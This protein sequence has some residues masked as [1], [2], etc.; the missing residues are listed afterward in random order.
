MNRERRRP[1]AHS[2]PQSEESLTDSDDDV[3]HTDDSEDDESWQRGEIDPNDSASATEEFSAHRGHTPAPQI[4]RRH[5]VN[6]PHHSTRYSHPALV[7]QVPQVPLGPSPVDYYPAMASESDFYGNYGAHPGRPPYAYERGFAP[8][9]SI[10][11]GYAPSHHSPYGPQ[12]GMVPWANGSPHPFQPQH[13]GYF[14]QG[15]HDMMPYQHPGYAVQ[16]SSPGPVAPQNAF[17]HIYPPPAA[18]AT[19]VG[20]PTRR[21]TPAPVEEKKPDPA[22]LAMQAQL[23]AMKAERKAADDAQKRA[24]LEKEIREQEERRIR[25]RMEDLRIASEAAKRDIEM[26]KVAAEAAAK[27]RIEEARR[28]EDERR[29]MEAELKAQAAR[30]ERERIEKERKAE[31]DRAAEMAK[32]LAEVERAAKEKYE[33]TKK[34]EA[35]RQAEQERQKK[36]IEDE[37]KAKILAEQKAAEEA[38]LAAELKLKELAAQAEV[39][40]E[41]L[42]QKAIQDH[43]EKMAA[44]KKKLADEETAAKAAKQQAHDEF[45]LKAAEEKAK[46][47]EAAAA[48][49]QAKKDAEK[50]KEQILADAKIE[51]EKKEAEATGDDKEP[52]KFKDAVGRKY[53][54]PWK[55]A[56]EWRVCILITATHT[57][58]P[59]SPSFYP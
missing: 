58:T 21:Q 14:E 2:A 40:R 47:K 7:P 13:P 30:E 39:E 12:Q 24:E 25:E 22:F 44:E 1:I 18:P 15:R 37:T 9:S 50:L 23:E 3:E 19:D 41:T 42:R 57:F 43:E 17:M 51:A 45:V 33:Q 53:S 5:S 8:Q 36:L 54:F 46:E 29:R 28:A 4:H 59:F 35:E 16:Y 48:A 38:K 27:E 49:E 10:A 34:E 52:V 56:K 11:P 6:R 20:G 26:A 55:L 32:T 31:A